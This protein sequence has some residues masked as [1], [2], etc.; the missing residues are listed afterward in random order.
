MYQE[1]NTQIPHSISFYP[2]HLSIMSSDSM[3]LKI[4]EKNE[5]GIEVN[6]MYVFYDHNLCTFGIRGGNKLKSG[7]IVSYSYYTDHVCGVIN[8]VNVLSEKFVKLSICLVNYHNLP[9][10]PDNITY[11]SLFTDDVG[12]NEMVGFDYDERCLKK[13][14][15]SIDREIE[16]YL[17]AMMNVYNTY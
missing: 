9:L 10:N 5:K 13:E 14:K 6:R 16:K 11:E 2:I 17:R 12:M 3:V 4:Y 1:E 7:K 8:M 15:T